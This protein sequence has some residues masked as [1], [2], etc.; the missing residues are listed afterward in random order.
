VATLSS[1]LNDVCGRI[2]EQPDS[3]IFWNLTGEIYPQMVD[4]EFEAA[5][6]TGVVQVPN[7]L[8]T[9]A[10]NQTYFDL[11]GPDAVVDKGML[12]PLRMRAPYPIRK[13]TL[14]G[15]DDMVPNWQQAPPNDQIVA[16]FP[17]GVSKFGIYPQLADESQ[18]LMDF[19]A[20]PVNEARPYSGDEVIPLQAEFTDLVS[21]YAAALLRIKEGGAEAE[22]SEGVYKDYLS[23]IKALSMF[24]G[25]LDNLVFTGAYGGRTQVNPRTEV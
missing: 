20:S 16:W 13:A 5:L 9:L 4:G 15:L 2:E 17:L 6:I 19:I 18:V 23:R 22:E 25:R 12:A 14:K 8:V 7:V 1:L 11:Q 10:A 24:Q 21:Q 3:P